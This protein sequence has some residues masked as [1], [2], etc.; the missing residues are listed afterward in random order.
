M[1]ISAG[2]TTRSVRSHGGQLIVGGEG[3]P[4]GS[5]KATPESFERLAEFARQHWDIEAVTHR[6][7]AHD[8]IPYDHLPMIGA[9]RPGASRLWVS[10]GFMKWGLATATFAAMILRDL[11][12]G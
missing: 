7:S 8:P 1:A 9:Y 11:I 6:W 10:A 3:H 4:T 12:G 5:G 2:G